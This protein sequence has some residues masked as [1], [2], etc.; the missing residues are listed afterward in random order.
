MFRQ[1]I[2][3]GKCVSY[4]PEFRKSETSIKITLEILEVGR[5]HATMALLSGYGSDQQIQV[6]IDTTVGSE[7]V[8]DLRIK[9]V[10]IYLGDLV[11][12]AEP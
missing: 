12:F 9:I 1:T 6:E 4:R 7:I 8:N 5:R 10:P 2:Q 3:K 11:G